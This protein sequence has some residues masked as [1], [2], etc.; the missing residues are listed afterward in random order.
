M[1]SNDSVLKSLEQAYR[2][3]DRKGFEEVLY[4]AIKNA[5]ISFC[6]PKVAAAED[7]A[8]SLSTQT[9]DETSSEAELVQYNLLLS[10]LFAEF[11][12]FLGNIS[13]PTGVPM[14]TDDTC[15]ALDRLSLK[16]S[17]LY[18]VCKSRC[19]RIFEE[20][21]PTFRCKDCSTDPSC[22]FCRPCFFASVHKNHRYQMR[23]SSGGYCDCGDHEAWKTGAWCK[24]HGGNEEEDENAEDAVFIARSIE[25]EERLE[26]EEANST[27][28][29]LPQDLIRRFTYLLKPLIESAS[30]I[31]FQLLQGTNAME[32]TPLS[33]DPNQTIDLD[34]EFDK[35]F[36]EDE[37][38]PALSHLTNT[39]A[40]FDASTLGLA[41]FPRTCPKVNDQTSIVRRCLNQL[42]RSHRLHPVLFP[43]TANTAC[44][45][46]TA[47]TYKDYVV[48]LHNNEFHNYEDVIRIVRRVDG[49]TSKQATLYAVIV[50]REGRTPILSNLTLD[51]AAGKASRVSEMRIGVDFFG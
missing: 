2:A 20:N 39:N 5:A 14:D 24:L 28:S 40:D 27:L 25:E 45:N 11:E 18:P 36:E 8:A 34:E 49:C 41:A 17:T 46:A 32:I 50:N 33:T 10:T 29:K 21:E 16:L 31:L 38:P 13:N 48:V 1:N 23:Q 35:P 6:Y 22:A 37:W 4:S 43:L 12:A 9:T 15:D 3:S 51:N 7:E 42:A 26:I 19:S 30:I 47:Q 44:R